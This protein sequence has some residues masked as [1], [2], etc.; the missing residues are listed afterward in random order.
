MIEQPSAAKT[1]AAAEFWQTPKDALCR[2]LGSVRTG[3]RRSKRTG[4]WRSSE[5]T[6][7]MPLKADQSCASLGNAFGIP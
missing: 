6:T 4:A 5:Q 7:L 1:L 2:A 3:Y